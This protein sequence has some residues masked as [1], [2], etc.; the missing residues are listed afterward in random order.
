MFGTNPNEE[1]MY[2]YQSQG[3]QN[4]DE[5]DVYAHELNE[6]SRNES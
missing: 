2:S 5:A 1:S 3:Y 6:L 4:M